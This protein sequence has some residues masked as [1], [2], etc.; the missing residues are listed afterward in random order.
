LSAQEIHFFLSSG[1]VPGVKF[2]TRRIKLPRTGATR[3]CRRRDGVSLEGKDHFLP[4]KG[5]IAVTM[6]SKMDELSQK[7]S[8]KDRHRRKKMTW[9]EMSAG[10]KAGVLVMGT[11][12]MILAAA[13]WRDLAKRPDEQ[14]NGSK[15]VWVAIIAINW[16]GPIAYF[17]RGRREVT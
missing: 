1:R 13:A 17:V 12:Q 7:Q 10:R 9:S 6:K 8:K 11:V 4:R 16:I 3:L 15:G 14:V 5:A 2:V